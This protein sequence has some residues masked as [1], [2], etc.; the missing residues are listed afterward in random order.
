MPIVMK[1][2]EEIKARLGI[3]KNGEVQNFFTNSCV[4]RMAKYIPY[5]NGVLRTAKYIGSDY[6]I[7]TSPYA[8]YQY[9]GIRQDGTH[10]VKHYTTPGTGTKWD[11]RMWSAEGDTVMKELQNY[12]GGK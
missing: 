6:V 4:K 12:V 2:T 7:Y 10:K 3:N 5:D 11:R 8:R 1:P 9:Y